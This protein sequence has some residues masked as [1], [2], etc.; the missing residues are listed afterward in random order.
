MNALH[1]ALLVG[2]QTQPVKRNDIET[3]LLAT[4]EQHFWDSSRS[5]WREM[6]GK[7]DEVFLWGYSVLF[8][9]FAIGAKVDPA[10]YKPRLERVF[11]RLNRYWTVKAPGGYAVLPGQSKNP[12]R[13][14]DDNAWVGLAA[15]EAYSATKEMKYL[16]V[17]KRAYRF[18]KSGEDKK[19]G[20]GIYWHE[21]KKESKNACVNAPA[22]MLAFKLF[23]VTHNDVF[24]ADGLRWF[25]WT[26]KLADKDLLIMD[27]MN[28]SGKIDRTKWSYNSACYI[29]ASRLSIES[30][31][32]ISSSSIYVS[33]RVE[34][35]QNKML[36]A[37]KTRWI[38]PK[39]KLIND[40][41][42]FAIHLLEVVASM[43]PKDAAPTVGAVFEKCRNEQGL[44]GEYWNRKPLP[45]ENLKLMYTASLLRT[46]LL[47]RTR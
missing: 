40:P 26:S 28:L 11:D 9:T 45:G 34:T 8:S 12:D 14:Y 38:D 42:M 1:L 47:C 16:D 41:G 7:D 2:F 18:V 39:T 23:V 6:A 43:D 19:L 25:D 13:Y 29:Q 22:A 35:N 46:T 27:N 3:T 10:T 17:A 5:R 44:L 21:N 4:I 31:I 24:R 37:S 20:G 33:D 36:D 32:R 30:A 15:M